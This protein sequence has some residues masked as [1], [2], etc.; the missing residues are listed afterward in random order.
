VAGARAAATRR[1]LSA[2]A[3]LA[4]AGRHP[5]Q[6]GRPADWEPLLRE[7]GATHLEALA[8]G[9]AAYAAGA[10]RHDLTV[11]GTTYRAI[12]TSA[13]RPW[14][15]RQLQARYEALPDAAAA[16]VRALLERHGCWE[17]LWRVMDFPC[18]HDPQGPRRS[19]ARR[20]W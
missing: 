11:Q 16:G 2:R 7:I 10:A 12:P 4:V 9:A 13:Y 19:A 17:P 6:D 14:C 15:L 5:G 3:R 20:G 8:A 18:E 1:G